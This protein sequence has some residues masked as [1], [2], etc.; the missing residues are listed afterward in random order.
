MNL[1]KEE[2]LEQ[3]AERGYH[4]LEENLTGFY[5]GVRNGGVYYEASFGKDCRKY[6]I[7]Q[8]ERSHGS[9][10]GCIQCECLWTSEERRCGD[11]W[12][13]KED[14]IKD[15]WKSY[16]LYGQQRGYRFPGYT[17]QCHT[18]N[19]SWGFAILWNL[20]V[21]EGTEAVRKYKAQRALEARIEESKQQIQRRA[22]DP[23]WQQLKQTTQQLIQEG[24]G[25][26]EKARKLIKEY[27][28]REKQNQR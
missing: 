24:K 9:D 20:L 4:P 13:A 15:G 5:K 28:D 25:G 7:L 8:S 18:V 17:G 22:T 19:W 1:I 6:T 27:L 10:G 16:D 3:L 2:V 23:A 21:E 11:R 12:I 14:F 26:K